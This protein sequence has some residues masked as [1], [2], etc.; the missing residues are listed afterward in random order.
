MGQYRL[1]LKRNLN[2]LHRILRIL[3][4]SWLS[5][6]FFIFHFFVHSFFT[7]FSPPTSI[8]ALLQVWFHYFRLLFLYFSLF[9]EFHPFLFL[10]LLFKSLLFFEFLKLFLVCKLFSRPAMQITY[11][12]SFKLSSIASPSSLSLIVPPFS[13]FIS[14]KLH[15]FNCDLNLLLIRRRWWRWWRFKTQINIF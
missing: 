15:I 2:I 7:L 14:F 11:V 4:I 8:I 13:L 9:P 1:I 5:S 3:L 12:L 6:V 10:F